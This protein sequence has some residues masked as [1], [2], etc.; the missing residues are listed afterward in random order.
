MFVWLIGFLAI[1]FNRI[2]S[3]LLL[4]IV[5]VTSRTYRSIRSLNVVFSAKVVLEYVFL[6]SSTSVCL[7]H[8]SASCK[9]IN[10]FVIVRC[11]IR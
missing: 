4:R 7:A 9:V 2:V 11:P 10:V 8:F 5:G 3:S 1:A 6:S